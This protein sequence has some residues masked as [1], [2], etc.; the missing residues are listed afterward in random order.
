MVPSVA[1]LM[2]IADGLGRRP[3]ELVG[4]EGQEDEVVL[5]RA[6]DHAMIGD[7]SRIRVERLSGDLFDPAI[8]VWRLTIARGYDSGEE[9]YAYDGEEVVLCEQ[10]EITFS[11]GKEEFIVGVG[12]SLHFKS[13]IPRRWWNSGNSRARFLIIGNFPKGLRSKLHR[14]IQKGGRK[15]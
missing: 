11:I 6:K 3:S 7:G 9:K 8:E 4:E 13:N 1:I 2:K 10:G 5:L 12:D 15:R 14:Q